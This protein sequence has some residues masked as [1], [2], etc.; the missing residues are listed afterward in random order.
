MAIGTI[1]E[2]QRKAARVAGFMHPFPG[3][4]YTSLSFMSGPI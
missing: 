4:T 1:D 2:L 3:V